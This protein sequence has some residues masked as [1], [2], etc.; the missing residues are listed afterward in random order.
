MTRK[1]HGSYTVAEFR[2]P[3]RMGSHRSHLESSQR[4]RLQKDTCYKETGWN[5]ALLASDRK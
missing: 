5:L 4:L 3:E 1:D 2:E